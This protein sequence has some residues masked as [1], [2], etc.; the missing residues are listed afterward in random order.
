MGLTPSLYQAIDRIL[1]RPYIL[2]CPLFVRMGIMACVRVPCTP[3]VQ[4]WLI[5]SMVQAKVLFW[6]VAQTR[7]SPN[8][9]FLDPPLPFPVFENSVFRTTFYSIQTGS[10]LVEGDI[11]PDL[12]RLCFPVHHSLQPQTQPCMISHRLIKEGHNA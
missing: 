2:P 4:K 11:F 6:S 7:L 12:V 5:G 10:V 1:F 3:C 8:H 9:F